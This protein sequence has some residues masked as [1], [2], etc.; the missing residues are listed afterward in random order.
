MLRP[1]IA[2]EQK[3]NTDSH[4]SDENAEIT[5]RIIVLIIT[6]TKRELC[7]TLLLP[8]FETRARYTNRLDPGDNRGVRNVSLPG[9]GT[10]Q[11]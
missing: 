4:C 10:R 9:P 6:N 5:S 3:F 1:C 7:A 8:Y 11:R 2:V